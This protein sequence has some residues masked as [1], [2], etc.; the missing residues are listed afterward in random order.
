[1]SRVPV[2]ILGSTGIVGQRLVRL[3]EDHPWFEISALAA[4]ARSAGK[5]YGE[6]VRWYV[7]GSVPES[8]AERTILPVDADALRRAG[9][10]RLVFSALPSTVA[11]EVEPKF[12]RAGFAVVSDASALRMEEDVPVLIPEVNPE[13]LRLLDAQRKGRGW[14][15]FVVT[16]PNCTA[17][18]LVLSLK[19]ILDAF[20]IRRVVVTSLQAISGAG[21]DGL[22]SMAIQDNVIPYISKE[23]EKVEVETLKMLGGVGSKGLQRARF[24]ISASCN[25]VLVYD[26]HTEVVHVETE[27]DSTPGEVARAMEGFRSRPQ[28]LRLPSAP[29]SPIVVRREVD[30]P[31]PRLDRDAGGGMAVVVGRIREDPA[32]DGGVKY[33]VLGH[34]TVRGAAGNAVLSA[35]LLLKEGWL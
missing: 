29:A 19:P 11:A 15:G 32:F 18:V 33:V 27:S 17:N 34:N 23:E 7:E 4:S 3:L 25:R 12:A 28:E 2:A 20:G 10:A 1:V 16:N 5:R 22:P 21:Y 9:G 26:G 6:A 35:E 31:Q 24:R 30:R 13:H 8:V 14:S